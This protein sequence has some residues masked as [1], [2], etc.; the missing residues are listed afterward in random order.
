MAESWKNRPTKKQKT[1]RETKTWVCLERKKKEVTRENRTNLK[2]EKWVWSGNPGGTSVTVTGLDGTKGGRPRLNGPPG[3][4]PPLQAR[5]H[6]PTTTTT[7]TKTKTR[8][9]T[10]TRTGRR[11]VPLRLVGA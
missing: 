4:P 1:G 3:P 9:R 5:P 11:Q 7:T 2:K 8:T 6:G 10:R